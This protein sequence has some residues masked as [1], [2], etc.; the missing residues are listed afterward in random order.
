MWDRELR[1]LGGLAGRDVVWIVLGSWA[2]SFGFLPRKMGAVIV[3]RSHVGSWWGDTWLHETPEV[4]KFSE[5]FPIP[6][7]LQEEIVTLSYRSLKPLG[8]V[9]SDP[10][11]QASGKA[12][13]RSLWLDPSV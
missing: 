5:K 4:V 2:L 1:S 12:G 9:P 8:S 13:G 6:I 10:R 7:N 3:L 11:Q